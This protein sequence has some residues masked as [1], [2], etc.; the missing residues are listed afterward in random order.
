M[1][2]TIGAHIL[3]VGPLEGVRER[4]HPRLGEFSVPHGHVWCASH[5]QVTRVPFHGHVHCTRASYIHNSC[6][7]QH[8]R[9]C[10]CKC[11]CVLQLAHN[12][13]T[14]T[15]FKRAHSCMS[16]HHLQYPKGIVSLNLSGQVL[17]SPRG[18]LICI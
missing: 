16:H 7:L 2:T 17:G 10:M 12:T 8:R 11:L 1:Q 18:Y 14:H 9:R 13:H 4:V 3:V 6:C 15:S 5:G